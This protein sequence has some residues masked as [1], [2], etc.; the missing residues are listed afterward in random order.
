MDIYICTYINTYIHIHISKSIYRSYSTD[1]HGIERDMGDRTAAESPDLPI[2]LLWCS[3][4]MGM[5][6]KKN[7]WAHAELRSADNATT[8]ET[9]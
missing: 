7:P 6:Y 5:G 2:T 4:Q 9:S 8:R 1:K 3:A